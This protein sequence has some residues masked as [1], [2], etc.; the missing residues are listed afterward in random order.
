MLPDNIRLTPDLAAKLHRYLDDGGSIIASYESGLAVGRDDFALDEWGVQV[1]SDGPRDSRGEPARG[2]VYDRHDFCQYLR[3]RPGLT[4]RLP[5]VEHPMYIRGLD[6]SAGPDAEVLADLVLPY[7]DRTWEHYISHLQAPSTGET[8]G[9]AVVRQGRVVYFC[10]PIHTQYETNAPRWVKIAFLAAVGLLLPDPV[11][12]HEGPSTLEVS[13]TGQPQHGR[14][15]VHLLHYIPERRGTEFDTVED[16][17]PLFG[18]DVSLRTATAADSVRLEPQGVDLPFRQA[19]SR[20]E[21]AVP[22][23]DGHQM[24]AV[25]A[26]ER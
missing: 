4:D 11:V 18:V 12:R 23:I 8:A 2:K 20:I 5:A 25:T 9:P 24:L 10:H 14:E 15:V 17:L 22:R 6:V 16:V 21:F 3:P 7:F 19:G 26:R 1:E 13:V